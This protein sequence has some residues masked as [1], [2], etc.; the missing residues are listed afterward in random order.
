MPRPKKTENIG[1]NELVSNAAESDQGGGLIMDNAPRRRH[2]IEWE[3]SSE[4][5]ADR[6]GSATHGTIVTSATAEQRSSKQYAPTDV[7]PCRSITAGYVNFAGRKTGNIYSWMDANDISDVEYQDLRAAMLSESPYVYDP[8][9]V[10]EDEELLKLPEW[11]NVVKLYES[12]YS[13]KDFS[14][15]LA[16]PEAQMKQVILKLP[17]GARNSLATIAKTMMD[18]GRLDS[19]KKVKILDEV[20]GTDLSLFLGIEG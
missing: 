8:I 19:I 10:I 16:L 6:A 13:A 5:G 3:G 2:V 9:F 4:G 7:I 11:R 1:E 17:K 20:L 15:I 14:E 12:M 18:N